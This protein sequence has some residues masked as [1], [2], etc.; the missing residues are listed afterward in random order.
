MAKKAAA[1]PAKQKKPPKAKKP[2]MVSL[3]KYVREHFDEIKAKERHTRN[4][5][6][7]YETAK[8]D[9]AAAKK[10]FEQ[11]DL[12]LRNMI[13]DGPDKQNKLPFSEPEQAKAEAP[14]PAAVTEKQITRVRILKDQGEAAK[15]KLPKGAEIDVTGSE[16]GGL[17]AEVEPG[18]ALVLPPDSYEAIGWLEPT[19]AATSDEWRKAPTTDLGLAPKLAEKLPETIGEL[20]DLRAAIAT[21]KKEWPKGIG[22]GKVTQVEDAVIGWLTAC[23]SRWAVQLPAPCEKQPRK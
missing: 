23:P 3:P 11:A 22:N 4:L 2:E 7:I 14:K 12:A 17:L 18:Y 5:E 8:A 6:A 1:K 16:A 15:G 20:E 21:G 9:A 13:A 10:A 19:P